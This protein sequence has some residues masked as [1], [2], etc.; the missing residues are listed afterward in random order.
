MGLVWYYR[1]SNPRM[2]A[3]G[4]STLGRLLDDSEVTRDL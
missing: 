2:A 3:L 1:T 4:R